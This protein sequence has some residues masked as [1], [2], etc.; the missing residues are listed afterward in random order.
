MINANLETLAEYLFSQLKEHVILYSLFKMIKPGQKASIDDFKDIIKSSY[1]LTS[2]KTQ[3]IEVYANRFLP[4]LRFAGAIEYRGDIL[5]R[6]INKGK[7]FGIINIPSRRGRGGGVHGATFLGASGPEK[8]IKLA[9][10]LKLNGKLTKETVV[11][12]GFRN[13]AN[14][15][16][17][18]NVA[19]WK[20]KS[21]FP[22]DILSDNTI[23]KISSIIGDRSKSTDFLSTALSTFQTTE[24]PSASKIGSH[25]SKKLGRGWSEGS[26]KRYGG[27]AKGWITYFE[28]KS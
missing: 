15:L 11:R 22:A 16:I 23:D 5:V 2:L 25:I 6:P 21:L 13:S 12:E 3:T 14:D 19:I 10:K 18:L 9:E 4:Y 26:K 24:K 27:A 7:D 20:D 1:S 8:A 28:M 17:A